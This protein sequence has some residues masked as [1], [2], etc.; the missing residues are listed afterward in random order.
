MYITSAA[1]VAAWASLSLVGPRA[2]LILLRGTVMLLVAALA[3]QVL[4][5]VHSHLPSEMETIDQATLWLF[6]WALLLQVGAGLLSLAD[7]INEEITPNS[8]G[9]DRV[10]GLI[11]D[12]YRRLPHGFVGFNKFHKLALRQLSVLSLAVMG[13]IRFAAAEPILNLFG[14]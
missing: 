2:L 11:G 3:I 12:A 4:T 9:V 6:V 10:H 14:A 1:M 5:K 7:P 13:I 8:K